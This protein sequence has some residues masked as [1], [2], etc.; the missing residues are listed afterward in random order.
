MENKYLIER[1]TRDISDG[2]LLVDLNG[3][4]KY[5]NPQ[6]KTILKNPALREDIKFAEL[7]KSD[8]TG[9]NDE[10]Y[11]YLLDSIYNKEEIHSG[12]L[13]YNNPDGDIR[14]LF[15]KSSF[16]FS[17]D[18]KKKLGVI[19]QF[20]D[21]TE[22]H[23]IHIKYYDA[24]KVLVAMIIVLSANNIIVKIWDHLNQPVDASYITVMIEIFGAIGTLL[25]LK[26]TSLTVHDLGLGKGTDLKKTIITDG[27]L[28]AV[29]LLATILV[30]LFIQ[31]IR[32]D[33]IAPDAPLFYW[34]NWEL[35]STLYPIT[36]FAQE[37]MTRGAAQGCL[38]MVLPEKTPNWVPIIISSLFFGAMHIHKDLIFMIGAMI[39]LSI[40]GFIYNKQ[41][42][43]WGLCIPQYILDLSIAILW[44]FK[45]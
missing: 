38:S 4:I 26:Y 8:N 7:M 12:A 41:K 27:F 31:R 20:S 45:A 9:K 44:G 15:V 21:V 19:L 39:L 35:S 37:L 34:N 40:F 28:T 18:G 17:D 5:I 23:K 43:I 6:G 3:N 14:Y 22:N 10:F 42:T 30:K 16:V 25:I 24:V 33:I 29:I 1:I 2:L 32:P 13:K 11:Q 36:V